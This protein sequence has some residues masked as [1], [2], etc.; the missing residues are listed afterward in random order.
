VSVDLGEADQVVTLRASNRYGR[1][2]TWDDR[3]DRRARVDSNTGNVKIVVVARAQTES[4]PAAVVIR[5]GVTKRQQ[6]SL[7]WSIGDVWVVR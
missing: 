1:E 7:V 5:L 6:N 2:D 4:D 3:R